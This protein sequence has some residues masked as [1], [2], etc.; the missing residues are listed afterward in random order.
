MAPMAGRHTLITGYAYHM[1]PMNGIH[2]R[3]PCTAHKAKEC[4]ERGTEHVGT[5]KLRQPVNTGEADAY[6]CWAKG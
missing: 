6:D 4:E 1:A 2:E 3:H 5:V